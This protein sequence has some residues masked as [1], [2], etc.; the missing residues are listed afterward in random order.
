MRELDPR[1]VQGYVRFGNNFFAAVPLIDEHY[2]K[3]L[4]RRG[5]KEYSRKNY[6]NPLAISRDFDTVSWR[7]FNHSLTFFAL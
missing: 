2:F 7:K 6:F 4:I 5:I 1:R 3:G